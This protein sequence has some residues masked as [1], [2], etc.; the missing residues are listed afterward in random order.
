MKKLL[1]FCFSLSFV[2][3]VYAQQRAVP[4]KAMRDYALRKGQTVHF[5]TGFEKNQATPLHKSTTT[6]EEEIIGATRYDLQSNASMQNR[7]HVY[8][9]GTIGATWTMGFED[10]GFAGRGTGYNYFDGSDWGDMPEE[11]IESIRTGWPSYAPYGENGELVVSHDFSAGELMYLT[12]EE[13]G[14]GDWTEAYLA[15]PGGIQISWNRSTTSGIDNSVMQVLAITWPTAN[16]GPVY[17][18]LD[19]ALLYS[20]SADGGATWDPENVYFGWH[21]I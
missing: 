12:R 3:A 7:I 6:I 15:G 4:T 14:T 1:L 8:E 9:D 2:F 18:G 10:P 17:E 21:N 19:G 13:K 20:R 11:R 16:G 5:E